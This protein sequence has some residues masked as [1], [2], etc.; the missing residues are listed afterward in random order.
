R[1]G[2]V[3]TGAS[4]AAWPWYISLR[5]LPPS[6]GSQRVGLLRTGAAARRALLLGACGFLTLNLGGGGGSDEGTGRLGALLGGNG[7]GRRPFFGGRP[8][9]PARAARGG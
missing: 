4:A 6:A 3:R 2:Q 9:G 7:D 8:S 1:N 5:P